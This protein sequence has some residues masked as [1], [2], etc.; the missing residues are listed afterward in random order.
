MAAPGPLPGQEE[1]WY[2]LPEIPSFF[3]ED[4]SLWFMKVES[5]LAVARI[6]TQKTMADVVV[7]ALSF[8]EIVVIKD[9][10]SSTPQPQ[11]LFN[12]IKARLIWNFSKTAEACLP[13]LLK[14]EA[15]DSIAPAVSSLGSSIRELDAKV[16][17]LTIQVAEVA[18]M[19]RRISCDVRGRSSSRERSGARSKSRE[20]AVC[21]LHRKYGKDAHYCIKPCSWQGN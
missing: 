18:N 7:S 20:A 12:Q 3:R 1:I 16:D 17:R 19:V 11:D 6:T 13:R 21:R 14:G 2:S 9:I 15:L 10:I 8:E 5:S 4:P